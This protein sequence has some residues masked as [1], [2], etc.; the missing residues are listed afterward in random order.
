MTI[1]VGVP[2]AAGGGGGPAVTNQIVAASGLGRVTVEADGTISIIPDSTGMIHIE[3]DPRQFAPLMQW[4][5]EVSLRV[6]MGIA[7]AN[8]NIVTGS[9]KGDFVMRMLGANGFVV[10]LPASAIETIGLRISQSGVHH[11]PSI[12]PHAWGRASI[13]NNV[14]YTWAG[15]ISLPGSDPKK[16]SLEGLM[17]GESG[18]Q[19]YVGF[20]P[21]INMNTQALSQQVEN[22]IGTDIPRLNITDL[23]TGGNV[24][25]N[26]ASMRIRG[27]PTEAQTNY[28]LLIEEG[29]LSA[30]I[31]RVRG[32]VGFNNVTPSALP[33]LY[34]ITNAADDRA[35]D[36]DTVAIAELADVVA[37]VIND[38]IGYGLLT[39]SGGG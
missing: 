1:Q 30:D 17:T 29:L 11:V 4:R 34:T 20:S 24:I 27:A 12:G 14:Q 5:D 18:A 39:A 8:N 3:S 22:M 21:S 19:N 13:P 23:L 26:A 6:N 36:A 2:G 31:L 9:V 7:Q 37:T 33:S 10:G 16:F 38:L 25:V 35:F 28:A 15:S 32:V